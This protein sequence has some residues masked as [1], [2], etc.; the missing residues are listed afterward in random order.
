MNEFIVLVL[1]LG[2]YNI[3][4]RDVISIPINCYYNRLSINVVCI[5]ISNC[6]ILIKVYQEQAQEEKERYQREMSMWLSRVL[7][8]KY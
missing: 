3:R 2:Y 8:V 5:L 7:A 1:S 4:V 6:C